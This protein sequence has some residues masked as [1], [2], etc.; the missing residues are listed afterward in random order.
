MAKNE[1]TLTPNYD[2][3]FATM[4]QE[5]RNQG[6]ASWLVREFGPPARRAE[7]LRAVQR[8]LAPLAIA[9]N[10]MTTREMVE[11]F[12]DTIATLN[13]GVDKLAGE[14]ESEPTEDDC[15]CA[16][17]SWYGD[18]HDSACPLAGRERE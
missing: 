3:M 14:L 4:I 7:V 8:F 11:Q 5:A 18:V 2:R 6:E 13:T 12:R 1:I 16:D 17:R 15:D 10:C 9:A